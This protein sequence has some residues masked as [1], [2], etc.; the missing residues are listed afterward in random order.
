MSAMTVLGIAPPA[1]ALLGDLGR[2]E[3]TDREHEAV[4]VR[5]GPMLPVRDGLGMEPSSIGRSS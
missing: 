4:R 1:P 5:K 2:D 3:H